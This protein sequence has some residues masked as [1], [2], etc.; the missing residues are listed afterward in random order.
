MLSYKATTNSAQAKLFSVHLVVGALF[1]SGAAR[2]RALILD[3]LGNSLGEHHRREVLKALADVA[4]AEGITVFGTCQD[5]L[6][7]KA[8]EV[9]GQTIIFERRSNVDVLNAPTRFFGTNPDAGAVE[10]IAEAVRAGRPL[11]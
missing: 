4:A 2:G 9:C 5:D 6:L 10:L 3:E 1:A 7:A 11:T 8:G